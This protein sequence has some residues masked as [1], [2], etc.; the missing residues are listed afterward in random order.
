MSEAISG[1]FIIVTHISLRS[2]GFLAGWWVV[3][4][5][6][7][8]LQN[9]VDNA[10][11]QGMSVLVYENL[12]TFRFNLQSRAVTKDTETLLSQEPIPLPIEGNI[13]LS[14]NIGLK[15]CPFCGTALQTL[16]S[17]STQRRF[18]ALAEKHKNF[19][20]RPY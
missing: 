1:T 4:F 2:C 11:R 17:G 9:L 5:C 6:C 13:C 10:G 20:K 12:G 3:M 18:E 19:D 8:G 15:F 16:I 7:D 14:V